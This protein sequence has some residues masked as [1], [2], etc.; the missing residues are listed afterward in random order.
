MATTSTDKED[1]RPIVCGTDFSAVAG[2]ALEIAAAMAR[3]LGT[4]LLLI[5]V[6]EFHGMADLD[7]S[8]FEAAL[9]QNQENLDRE[10]KRLREL[11]TDVEVKML[12]GSVFDE[13]VTAA[14]KAKART[15]VVGAVGHS[16]ARRLLVGSVAE[17]TAET[18]P[19][20][21]L[22]VRPGTRLG[23]WLRGEHPLKI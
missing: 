15:V 5:H 19:I 10:A 14:I 13:L 2:E 11:G 1:K 22:V 8:L 7:P 17:R 21:T 23:S 12:S 20:P 4:K 6:E 18:S 3:R 16:L 9:S